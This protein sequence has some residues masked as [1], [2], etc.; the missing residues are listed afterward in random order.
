MTRFPLRI[1]LFQITMRVRVWKGGRVDRDAE[2]TDITDITDIT[3]E[4][5]N[6]D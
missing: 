4:A 6:F 5:A 2:F 3:S 1:S